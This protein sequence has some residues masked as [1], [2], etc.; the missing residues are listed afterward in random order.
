MLVAGA[1]RADVT[2]ERP[3]SILI[4]P[5]VVSD[6][7]RDTIIQVTNTSNSLDTARCFYLDGEKGRS[8][9]PLCS[10]TDFVITL[11]K[12]QP[13]TWLA[14]S[15]RPVIGGTPGLSP[16]LIPAVPRGFTGALICNEVDQSLAPLA[17]NAI[18]G[19]ATLVG[20]GA[21]VSKYN[22]VAI[23]GGTAAGQNNQD[24]VLDLNGREYNTCPAT[25]RVN[26][27]GSNQIEPIIPFIGNGGLCTVGGF[28]CTT[29]TDCTNQS[30]GTCEHRV[31]S[32]GSG[33]PGALCDSD[34]QCSPGFC[35]VPLSSVT[36]NVTVLPCNLDLNTLT[37]TT[38]ALTV[39]GAD[40]IETSLSGS[41]TFSCWDN[42]NID[43][44]LIG[45]LGTEF[46]TITLNPGA[47]GPVLAVVET[48]H[49]DS[50]GNTAS[51]ATNAHVQGECIASCV[52]TAGTVNT[53]VPCLSN[54]DCA[55]GQT[56]AAAGTATN[57]GAAC[58][59]NSDCGVNEACS[60]PRFCSGG[61]RAGT[62][63][64]DDTTCTGNGKCPLPSAQI[65]LPSA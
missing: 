9:Q 34:S 4:F 25:T 46:G 15:G 13:T 63:C 56:C 28:P 21:D 40:G 5:K 50:L 2:T 1:A 38:V 53:F 8:G 59:A 24:N 23:P 36:T 47:G 32:A 60:G 22:G 49:S 61:T 26:F 18:K 57:I 17:M 43:S 7:T 12:Q 3:G 11:T 16:G 20:P 65:V 6:G 52:I 41:R 33:T 44:T 27:V 35:N 48:F 55:S 19:E 58:S 30:G 54:S 29:T 62:A 42:F 39:D 45:A 37:P 51:A 31:C 10:E 64:V 14:G